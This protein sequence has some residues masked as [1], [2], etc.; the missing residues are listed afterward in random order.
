[1][2]WPFA[3]L[4][5]LKYGAILADPP[6]AY[7]MRS[8]KGYEKSP[9]AHYDTMSLNDIKALPVNQLASGDC[10]L[11][12]WSTWPHLRQAMEV[13][14]AWG[15]TYKTG[16]SWHKQTATGKTAFGTGYILRSASE[17]FLIGTIGQPTIRNRGQRNVITADEWPSSIDALRREHS[18]KPPEARQMLD[19]LF[20]DVFK[21][22]LFAREPWAGSDVWGNQVDKFEGAA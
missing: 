18:R 21:A 7:A 13:M 6:W 10:L 1:M 12:M 3:R 9:E 16:G 14:D 2:I 4:T 17:P 11:F 19:V 5:P 20:P 22:E 8:A 15:F